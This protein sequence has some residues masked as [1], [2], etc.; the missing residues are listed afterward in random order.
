MGIGDAVQQRGVHP[1]A[2][3]Q[4]HL[5]KVGTELE[6]AR[7]V[8]HELRVLVV[9]VHQAVGTGKNPTHQVVVADAA[10]QVTV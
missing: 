3:M 10:A 4:G 1:T 6:V 2:Q 9:P 5:T 7:D 8:R